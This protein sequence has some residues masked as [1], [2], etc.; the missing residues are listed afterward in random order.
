MSE[1][2]GFVGNMYIILLY[3]L[4]AYHAVIAISRMKDE[5]YKLISVGIV[6]LIVVQAFVNI[7]VNSN[8]IPNTGLTLPFMSYGGT[9]LMINLIEITLLYKI[10]EAKNN[11][12]Q[13]SSSTKQWL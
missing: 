9:A 1:E 6:S 5:Q 10:I 7:G 8:L 2:I 12:K 3:F 4:L 11:K 13:V